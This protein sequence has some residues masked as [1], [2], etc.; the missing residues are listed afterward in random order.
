[1]K[2]KDTFCEPHTAGSDGKT[3]PKDYA[4]YSFVTLVEK[5]F[6]E[7]FKVRLKDTLAITTINHNILYADL[8]YFGEERSRFE[9]DLM[10]TC[11]RQILT[12]QEEVSSVKSKQ[13]CRWI[14]NF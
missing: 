2:F 3:H 8:Y 4:I 10:N 6:Y 1:V 7:N 12:T 14:F 13:T 9:A 11:S 5:N